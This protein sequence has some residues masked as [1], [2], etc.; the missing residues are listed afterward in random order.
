M[1]EK[2]GAEIGLSK[3]GHTSGNENREGD[4]KGRGPPDLC[5]EGIPRPVRREGLLQFR[6]VGEP[7]GGGGGEGAEGGLMASA[8]VLVW[9]EGLLKEGIGRKNKKRGC[10]GAIRAEAPCPKR[11]S[12]SDSDKGQGKKREG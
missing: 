4:T 5:E 2:L 11:A 6:R 10:G 12:S 7:R 9:V 8:S 1:K 3:S